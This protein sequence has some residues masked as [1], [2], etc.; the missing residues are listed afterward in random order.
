[1]SISAVLYGAFAIVVGLIFLFFGIR[2]FRTVLATT[3]FIVASLMTFIL[4][5]NLREE[6]HWGPHGDL[7]TLLLCGAMGI[8]GAIL[9][10][11][12]WMLALVGIGGLGGFTSA[13]WLLSWK[14]Q[15]LANAPIARPIF[16]VLMTVFGG[17]LAIVYERSIIILGTSIIGSVALCSGVD[18]FSGTGFNTSLQDFLKNKAAPHNLAG[19]TMALLGSCLIITVLG[20]IV[21]VAVTGRDRPAFSRK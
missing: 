10:L 1:M 18:V 13:L 3:G 6:Y 11:S 21:Q 15:I 4:I 14:G 16:L 5:T 20:V 12:M 17:I 8:I 19:S 9:G 2:M 7:Y